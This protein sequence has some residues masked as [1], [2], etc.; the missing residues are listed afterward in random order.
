VADPDAQPEWGVAADP[1]SH[2]FSENA[3][4]ALLDPAHTYPVSK[5]HDG[6]NRVV[7][8]LAPDGS[9]QGFLFNEAGQLDR[10][11]L[12]HRGG[13]AV[14]DIVSR[15]DYD[16]RAQRTRIEYGNGVVTDYGYDSLTFRLR[17]LTSNRASGSRRLLQDLHYSHDAVGNITGI[18]DDAHQTVYFAGLSVDPQS[19]FSYDALYRL[20]E[21]TGREHIA[22]G[23]CHDR[24][25]DNQQ[26]ENISTD[27]N[28]QPVSNAQAL[29]NYT[30]RYRY[31]DG[32]NIT[33][34]R[35][36]RNGAT[37]WLRTQTYETASNRIKR[38]EAG[39]QGEGVDLSH[40][41]NGNMLQLAHLPR[42]TW[43]DRNQL[44]GA[45]LNIAAAN[46]DRANYHY[47]FAGRR[48]RKTV[49]RGNRVEQRIYVGGLELFVV[50]DGSGVTERWE[51]L[52]LADGDGRVALVETRTAP[53]D[54]GVVLETL[55][56]F[57][58][59][60]HLGSAVLETDGSAAARIISYEE[61]TPYGGT[62]YIAGQKLSEVRRK[63]Y[64][65]SGKERD[66]E[67]GLYYY[68][69]RYLAPW[70]GR[71]LS[72]D[73]RGRIDGLAVYAFCRGN[74]IC[75]TDHDGRATVDL[76]D[77][78]KQRLAGLQEEVAKATKRPTE[79]GLQ[80]ALAAPQQNLKKLE[81]ELQEA[82]AVAEAARERWRET[83]RHGDLRSPDIAEAAVEM[84]AAEAKL[85]AL[86]QGVAEARELVTIPVD[87]A[88]SLSPD[89]LHAV[90]AEVEDLVEHPGEG[91]TDKE[92]EAAKKEGRV[93][94]RLKPPDPP[95]PP[96]PPSGG[97][98][99]PPKKGFVNRIKGLFKPATDKARRVATVVTETKAGR[100]MGELAE[101]GVKRGKNFIPVIGSA[102]GGAAAGYALSQGDIAGAYL[103]AAGASEIPVVAQAADIAN[104]VN[105]VGGV[106]KEHLDPEQKM[107][108]FWYDIGGADFF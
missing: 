22:F 106:L 15:I 18:R 23:P 28:G 24:D 74:P 68:G 7:S 26:T 30:Q 31:D 42:M 49:T 14:Q 71:W 76:N 37:R 66:N 5:S 45:Q 87:K 35:H 47:D 41:A 57:Q 55:T 12:R 46:P 70:M 83:M 17:R 95:G 53:A 88:A 51:V 62:A 13:A 77:A 50:R 59:G 102:A 8:S 85:P 56:R 63:R 97:G 96:M 93:P 60:N 103:E 19:G 25:G 99:A 10:V 75:L 67:T 73:P 9:V 101:V 33:Q 89:E 81:A 29:A 11:T 48:V 1:L 104:L 107:E 36:L 72:C 43:D 32:G 90:D 6:L 58:F 82:Q 78:E 86:K 44:I 3:A 98:A 94:D 79:V 39:C 21:A 27:V 61:Y 65:Y 91:I 108:G 2:A 84:N 34:I 105:D 52:H 92:F 100:L 38:S 64:R 54:P 16:A 40:D 80:Q 20:T 4:T 69:A